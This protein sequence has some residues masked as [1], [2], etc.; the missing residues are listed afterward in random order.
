[1]AFHRSWLMGEFSGG[2]GGLR[3]QEG[4][5]Q[6]QIGQSAGSPQTLEGQVGEPQ[7]LSQLSPLI[8]D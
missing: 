1:M 7:P 8:G 3:E 4:V 5:A 2:D 6:K